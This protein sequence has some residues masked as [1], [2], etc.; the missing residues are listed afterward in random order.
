MTV[1]A[2]SLYR[3]GTI[4]EVVPLSKSLKA[5]YLKYQVGYR[6][7][8]FQTGPNQ[9][10]WLVIV[11]YADATEYETKQAL[12]AQNLECQQLF[13]EIAKFA[14]RISRDMAIDLDL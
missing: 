11:T 12:F 5:I 7:S 8:R 1:S 3:G 10:D 13:T 14:T 9:G 4:E 2:I 6:L